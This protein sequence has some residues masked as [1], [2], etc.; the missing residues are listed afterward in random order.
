MASFI[1]WA[2]LELIPFKGLATLCSLKLIH[3]T[4]TYFHTL[5]FCVPACRYTFG[6]V[7]PTRW[8]A[9]EDA[10]TGASFR[11]LGSLFGTVLKRG[12]SPVSHY[13]AGL[14]SHGFKRNPAW[15]RVPLVH[16][17]S[18]LENLTATLLPLW[19]ICLLDLKW[20]SHPGTFRNDVIWQLISVETVGDKIMNQLYC[21]K[22]YRW[23]VS[24]YLIPYQMSGLF[25]E[26]QF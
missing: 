3:I 8:L 23:L 11:T 16:M 21:L 26:K 12:L 17:S 2:H 19:L 24:Y 1:L 18:R 6:A 13:P 5:R 10:V 20:N 7:T 9:G 22:F 25:L 15:E 14:D 4:P